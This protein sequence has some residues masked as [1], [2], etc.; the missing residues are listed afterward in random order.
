MNQLG[1]TLKYLRGD[2]TQDEISSELGISKVSY[3]RYENGHREPNYTVILKMADYFN[4]STDFLL[5]RMDKQATS[6]NAFTIKAFE[7]NPA[8]QKWYEELPKSREQDV[9]LIKKIWEVVSSRV[10]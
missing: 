5:G 1:L 10:N 9:E 6:T 8:L 4:V 3:S 7:N 2:R